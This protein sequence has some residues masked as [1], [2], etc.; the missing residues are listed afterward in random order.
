MG[1]E[2][3][4][5]H[6]GGVS[7]MATAAIDSEFRCIIYILYSEYEISRGAKITG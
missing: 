7:G 2:I 3:A 1:L 4:F 6:A 5:V